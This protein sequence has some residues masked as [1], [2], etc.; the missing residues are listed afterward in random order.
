MIFEAGSPLPIHGKTITLLAGLDTVG[1]RIG[2]FKA[3][4]FQSG[5][6]PDQVPFF[7]FMGNVSD[8]SIFS[9]SWR[10]D[11]RPSVAGAGKSVLWYVGLSIPY[12]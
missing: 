5:N 7:G 6:C 9:F 12:P 2:S 10:I 8:H 11:S 1:P 3:R 4:H